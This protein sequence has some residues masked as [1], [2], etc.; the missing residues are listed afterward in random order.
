MKNSKN[1][2]DKCYPEI[3]SEWDFNKN[4][5]LTPDMV[6]ATSGRKVWWQCEKGHEW[7]ALISNRT[8]A[9]SGCPYCAGKKAIVGVN[10]LATADPQLAS[11]WHPIKNGSLTPSD[12]MSSSK[13]K[14]WWICSEEHEWN[15]TLDSRNKGH[16]CPYC[17]GRRA[18]KGKND[19]ASHRPDIAKLWHPTKN[20]NKDINEVT[21]ASGRKFW[22]LGECGHEWE[23]KVS[24]MC[25]KNTLTLCPICNGQNRTSFPEQAIFFYAQMIFPDVISRYGTQKKEIDVYSP[26]MNIGFE[27]DGLLYHTGSTREVEKDEYFA[28]KGITIFHF[29]VSAL[30]FGIIHDGTR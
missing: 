29:N 17:S 26:S 27:Y 9:K 24:T 4:N 6:T 30:Y 15:A 8:R 14:I 13:K 21:V 7:E 22:W 20:G 18:V 19:L 5:G 2:L 25:A 11:E 12:V 10:D 23:T 16:G 1:T 3:A 28:E